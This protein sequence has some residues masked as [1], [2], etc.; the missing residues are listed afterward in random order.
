MAKLRQKSVTAKL[1][2]T[3]F[4]LL[5]GF[6]LLLALGWLLL[7]YFLALGLLSI[8]GAG[9]C[10]WLLV[11]PSVRWLPPTRHDIVSLD[12]SGASKSIRLVR[13]NEGLYCPCIFTP[14]STKELVQKSVNTKLQKS[15]DGTV[16]LSSD[17]VQMPTYTNTGNYQKI[18]LEGFEFS[19]PA[20]LVVY[21]CL[22]VRSD[23]DTIFDAVSLRKYL[24][25]LETRLVIPALFVRVV[26]AIANVIYFS[27]LLNAR[28]KA[29][30]LLEQGGNVGANGAKSGLVSENSP[31]NKGVQYAN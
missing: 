15:V 30:T 9:V 13:T 14:K 31:N 26:L 19:L 11:T 21:A 7:P 24:G 23:K 8:G 22:I 20:A 29:P 2:Q 27:F 6:F 5:L 4:F 18:V 16:K 10:L 12:V 25:Y 1:R 28:F 17:I 3:N